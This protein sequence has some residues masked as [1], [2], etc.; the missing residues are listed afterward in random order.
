MIDIET[1]RESLK[2]S[3]EGTAEWRRA[4]AQE[5]PNDERNLQA[6]ESLDRLATTVDQI[7]PVLLTAYTKL[8]DGVDSFYGVEL[9]S[10]MTRTVGFHWWPASATEFVREFIER[11]GP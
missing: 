5:Y 10:E 7:E 4:K 3:F 9:E 2:Y 8:F 1:V 11:R 6:A